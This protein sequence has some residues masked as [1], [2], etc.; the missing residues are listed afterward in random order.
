MLPV[1][2]YRAIR[3]KMKQ[4]NNH[5]YINLCCYLCDPDNTDKDISGEKQTNLGNPSHWDCFSKNKSKIQIQIW[6]EFLKNYI[7]KIIESKHNSSEAL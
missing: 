3:Q 6:I 1:L 7:T 2:Y 4:P 5:T